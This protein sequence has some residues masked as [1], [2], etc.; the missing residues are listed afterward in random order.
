[1]KTTTVLLTMLLAGASYAT[2]ATL[3]NQARDTTDGLYEVS[4]DD[5]GNS[6]TKFTPIDQI[7]KSPT[8]R[9]ESPLERRRDACGP[10]SADANAANNAVQ[11]LE[12]SFPGGTRFFSKDNWTYVRLLFLSSVYCFGST[13]KNLYPI[14]HIFAFLIIGPLAPLSND[15]KTENHPW[16]QDADIL[17]NTK[18]ASVAMSWPSSA[19][20]QADT[21][22]GPTFRLPLT[23][24]AS[25]V[26][27]VSWATSRSTAGRE[28]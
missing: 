26:A 3:P 24:S 4:V 7:S 28:I 20:T 1:M 10:G 21:N 27:A 8:P 11:C 9:S 6:N 5:A 23:A 15:P 13:V 18:S 17:R 2:A 19:P 12:D 25:D 16:N 22:T 14:L